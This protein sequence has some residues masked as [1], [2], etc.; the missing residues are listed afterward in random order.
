MPFTGFESDLYRST[1][2]SREEVRGIEKVGDFLAYL[3]NFYPYAFVGNV[4]IKS[5]IRPQQRGNVNQSRDLDLI[6]F[7]SSDEQKLEET[8]GAYRPLVGINKEH[9]LDK[10]KVWYT[11]RKKKETVRH[12]PFEVI[13][14][15]VDGTTIDL[16]TYFTGIGPIQINEDDKKC[17]EYKNDLPV[18]NLGYLLATNLNPNALTDER[19]RRVAY[20]LQTNECLSD[21]VATFVR[22]IKEAI[23]EG[24]IN[25]EELRTALDK[26]SNSKYRKTF[27]NRG[28]ILVTEQLLKIFN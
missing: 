4:A 13:H 20:M 22:K 6:I 14:A 5:F 2:L 11:G 23:N 7:D 19:M 1:A 27:E 25:R 3:K 12:S 8:I 28:I 16:F 9:L 18:M 17:V 10:D 21:C 26:L 15:T 24:N